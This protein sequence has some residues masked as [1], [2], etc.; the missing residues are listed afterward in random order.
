MIKYIPKGVCAKEIQFDIENDII[1]AKSDSNFILVRWYGS[2][3]GS[4]I[5]IGKNFQNLFIRQL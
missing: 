5:N 4:E 2:E 3:F 1:W